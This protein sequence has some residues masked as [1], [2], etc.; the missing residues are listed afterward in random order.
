MFILGFS[1]PLLFAIVFP[2]FAETGPPC[3]GNP[4]TYENLPFNDGNSSL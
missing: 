1:N 3:P 2:A 4:L